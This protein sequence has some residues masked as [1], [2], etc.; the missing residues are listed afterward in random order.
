MTTPREAAQ[1]QSREP[2]FRVSPAGAGTGRPEGGSSNLQAQ[3]PTSSATTNT[4]ME[5]ALA[6]YLGHL[7]VERGLA[8]N[9]IDAYR[10]DLRGLTAFLAAAGVHNLGQVD[11]QHLHGWLRS[12]ADRNLASS[13]IARKVEAVRGLYRYL[14]EVHHVRDLGALLDPV[15]KWQRVPKVVT[16][17]QAAALVEAPEVAARLGQRDR[18]ILELLYASGL[19]VSELCGLKLSDV[20][21]D[22]GIVRVVGKGNKE[23]IVPVG[24]MAIG[25]LR[26]YIA[27]ERAAL[28]KGQAAP[29][30]FVSQT[31]RPLDRCNVYAA[32]QKYAQAAG[33]RVKVSPHTLRH[34]FATHLLQGG[35]NLRVV[36]ELLGHSS[37]DTTGKYLHVDA[38]RLAEI[39]RQHHPLGN[40]QEPRQDAP[41]PKARARTRA[42]GRSSSSGAGNAS[43]EAQVTVHPLKL[44]AGAMDHSKAGEV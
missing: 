37:I 21:L 6:E 29:E 26:A 4:A 43:S 30:L 34:C 27:G 42:A 8:A 5:S 3:N 35:A 38:A 11:L 32:V 33:I 1:S 39:H 12:L 31:G 14:A 28:L 24:G 25:A 13:T 9:S 40:V 17:Q 18:A 15:K 10:T 41:K 19:R 2:I 20:D 22:G 36:Q 7:R 44:A 23:R 16:P